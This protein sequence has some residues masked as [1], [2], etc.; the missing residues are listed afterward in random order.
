MRELRRNMRIVGALVAAAFVTLAA[1]FALTVFEQGTLWASDSHNTRLNASQT[2]R[3]DITDRRGVTLASTVDGQRVYFENESVRRA[4]AAVVGDTA[5]MSGTGVEG[6]YSAQLLDISDS[7][8]E[9]LSAL[10]NGAVRKGSAIEL[11][12]D[13]QW[14]AYV[15]TVFPKGYRGAVCVMNYRTGEILVM[16]SRPDYDPYALDSVEDTAFLNRNLQGLYTPGS[17]FKIVTLASA[18]EN[19]PNVVNQ[20]FVCSGSWEYE[21]GSIV[22][23]GQT[24]HG[25]VTLRQAFEKSCNVTFGKLAYQLGIDRL[26][27]TAERMGFNEN[28][29][30]GDFAIYNSKFPESAG[31]MSDLVWAGIGQGTVLVT[32]LHMTMITSGVANDGTIMLPR[33]VRRVTSAAGTVSHTSA[34]TPW[35]QVLSADSA[36]V[37]EQYMYGAVQ[38]GTA[39]RAQINGLP[40]CGKTGSAETSNDKTIAT[41]SW[42]TGFIADPNYPYAISVIIEHGGSGSR[43]ASELASKALGWV[44]SGGAAP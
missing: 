38:S 7:L 36:A 15:S 17:V 21:G 8:L 11:T 5:G 28:L 4:L 42:Y 19:D 33:L 30:L 32:P 31:N 25:T 6:Y 3:G 29:K 18:L 1:W 13:A 20:T 2:R 41:H 22:C 10:F 9:R 27:A 26:R 23:A 16:V 12:I 34:P 39:V 40:V 43:A 24:A 14:T 35:R 44:T 37:I